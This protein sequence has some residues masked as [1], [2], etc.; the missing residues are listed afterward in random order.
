MS[1]NELS[2][3]QLSDLKI[4]IIENQKVLDALKEEREKV[5]S[6]NVRLKSDNTRL[7]KD[8]QMQIYNKENLVKEND[9]LRE[10]KEKIYKEYADKQGKVS[11]EITE[12]QREL[13]NKQALIEAR[14]EEVS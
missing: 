6:E 8:V 1:K 3:D 14:K 10:E 5:A 11:L 7:E 2:I 9:K 13:D 4:A 12:R